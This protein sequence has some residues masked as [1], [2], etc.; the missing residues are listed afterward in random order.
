MNR[1]VILGALLVAT[2]TVSAQQA[3]ESV[4][5]FAFDL[6]KHIS[7]DKGENVVFAPFS[8]TPAFGMVTLGAKDETEK[9]LLQV[10]RFPDN[11]PSLHVNL[12]KL[13]RTIQHDAHSSIDISITNRVWMEKT[14]RVNPSYRRSL[15][16]FYGAKVA[17]ADFTRNPEMSREKINKTVQADTKNYIKNLL[18]QGSVTGVTRLVLTNAI[19]FKGKWAVPFDTKKT[20]QRNFSLSSGETVKCA[21]MFV[22]DT[23]GYFKG[24]DYE[25]LQLNYKG[26]NLSMLILLPN[27]GVKILDFEQEL[28]YELYIDAINGLTRD[29]FGVYLPKFRIETGLSLK[30]TL[31]EM[32]MPVAFTD[33]ADFSGISGKKDLKISDAFHKAFIEV[34]EEG[35]TAA[36]AT[37]VVIAIKSMPRMNSFAANRPFV[38][39]LRHNSSNTILFMGK[40]ENPNK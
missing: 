16:K 39:I 9:Q 11:Q 30:N 34:S 7:M 32:G 33:N 35:T 27:E 8:I 15:Q 17:P 12:G 38:Y 14:Y 2:Q 26:N 13:Q 40:V 22:E 29:K 37:A 31:S 25:A 5:K 28:S 23:M 36:A 4:S 3:P 21:T 19:Y 1:V 20:S 10:F 24:D 18:P 6:Y